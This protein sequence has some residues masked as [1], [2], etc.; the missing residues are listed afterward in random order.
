MCWVNSTKKQHWAVCRGDKMKIELFCR[1]I[2]LLTLLCAGCLG[3]AKFK[4]FC[5]RCLTL[6]E[7]CHRGRAW[8]A[9]A[10]WNAEIG[11]GNGGVT[12][13]GHCPCVA[14]NNTG[15]VPPDLKLDPLLILGPSCHID[16]IRVYL[17]K[18]DSFAFSWKLVLWDFLHVPEPVYLL[19][20]F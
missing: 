15:L 14:I 9:G 10:E 4:I 8:Q 3:A 2:N 17:G 16:W 12:G 20:I 5:A 7:L 18:K 19:F 13:D 6:R 11:M 1:T